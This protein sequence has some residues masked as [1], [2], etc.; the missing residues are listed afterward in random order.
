MS[1]DRL[2]T[3]CGLLDSFVSRTFKSPINQSIA[4]ETKLIEAI[5]DSQRGLNTSASQKQDILSAV[6]E[7]ESIGRGTVTTNEVISATWK[8]LWTTEKV[9]SLK[10]VC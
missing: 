7:L 1:S 4:A 9:T 3:S 5:K 8:L 10:E 6:E 2:R